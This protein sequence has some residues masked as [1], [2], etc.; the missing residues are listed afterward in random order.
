MT[1]DEL[2]AASGGKLPTTYWH[3]LHCGEVWPLSTIITTVDPKHTQVTLRMNH[4][5][6]MITIPSPMTLGPAQQ[7]L[8]HGPPGLDEKTRA[9]LA[10]A[11]KRAFQNIKVYPHTCPACGL[12]A[13][14]GATEVKCSS[15]Q[16]KFAER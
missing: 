11:I 15:S 10:D 9:D 6:K 5:F 13:Y 8:Y 4:T 14:C 3:C 7:T 2:T 1:I 16:C 12:A